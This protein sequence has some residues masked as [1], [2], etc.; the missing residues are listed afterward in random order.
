MSGND[1]DVH[2]KLCY[3]V[4]ASTNIDGDFDKLHECKSQCKLFIA[5]SNGLGF[6]M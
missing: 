4:L 2:L 6:A 5:G 3:S 1:G